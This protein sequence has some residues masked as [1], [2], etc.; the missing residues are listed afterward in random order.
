M[1][2]L[3]CTGAGSK[4]LLTEDFTNQ[5]PN[6]NLSI[7]GWKNIAESG[8]KSFQIKYFNNN[9]YAEIS[10]FASNQPTVVSW[11]IL[12]SVNLSNSANEVLSFQ[13]K[14]GFD[15]G[16][17]LQVFASTN[18]DGGSTPWKAKWTLLKSI[19][20]KGSV[21]GIAAD[22]LASGNISLSGYS[23]TVYIAFRYDGADPV[24]AFDKRTTTFQI[25]NIRIEGN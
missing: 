8:G 9:S 6:S 16:G 13:T 4:L 11:L 10:A 2:G 20:S 25:D 14:D 23:G 12:P 24:L 22:W 17:V 3:R 19:I 5:T 7:L 1:K 18:Y 15:N 21:S